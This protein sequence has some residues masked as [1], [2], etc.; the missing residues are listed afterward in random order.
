MNK[1]NYPSHINSVMPMFGVNLFLIFSVIG[2]LFET[3]SY[4]IMHHIYKPELLLGPW[5]PIYGFGFLIAYGIN[6]LLE[7]RNIKGL[8][9]L[10]Y[11]FIFLLIIIT[12]LEAI[13]GYLVEFLFH[14][15]YWNYTSIPFHIGKYVS[16]PISILW[17]FGLMFCLYFLLPKITS[18]IKK[19]PAWISYFLLIC[20]FIDHI[21]LLS[22]YFIK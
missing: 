18:F 8:K 11:F 1:E 4:F 10:L 19:I 5:L 22:K 2:Y 17:A 6:K 21:F 9:K 14:Q 15:E 13:G 16:I 3:I 12:V 20:I 7:K